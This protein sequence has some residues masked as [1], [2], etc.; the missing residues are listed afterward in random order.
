MLAQILPA[1]KKD[2]PG[3]PD[4]SARR[5]YHASEE[6]FLTPPHTRGEVDYRRELRHLAAMSK[7][8]LARIGSLITRTPGF[9]AGRPRIAAGA[10]G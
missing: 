2:K 5:P 1:L 3:R 6:L 10:P 8:S 7:Q 9:H 4:A